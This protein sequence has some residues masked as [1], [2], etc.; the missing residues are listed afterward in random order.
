MRHC[1]TSPARQLSRLTCC[2]ITLTTA[3]VFH[4][5][6]DDDTFAPLD[7]ATSIVKVGKVAGKFKYY[8]DTTYWSYIDTT[9]PKNSVL[10]ARGCYWKHQV[11]VDDICAFPIAVGFS[12]DW[13]VT[14]PHGHAYWDACPYW[15]FES[16]PSTQDLCPNPMPGWPVR[17]PSPPMVWVGG[18]VEGFNSLKATWH[19]MKLHSPSGFNINA[20][21]A[22]V[23]GIR[24]HNTGDGIQLYHSQNFEVRNCWFSHIRDEPIENDGKR[25]GTMEDCLVDGCYVFYSATMGKTITDAPTNK[26]V[27]RNNIVSLQPMP[28]PYSKSVPDGDPNV[29]GAGKLFKINDQSPLMYLYDNVFVLQKGCRNYGDVIEVAG[30]RLK[31]SS[32]NKVI[33][34][35]DGAFEA[36]MPSGFTLVTGAKGKAMWD[37]LK[38]DWIE[39]HPKV[40]RIQGDPG[41]DATAEAT[42]PRSAGVGATSLMG[43]Q[44]EAVLLGLDGRT[45]ARIHGAAAAHRISGL[46]LP[47]GVYVVR[48]G[49]GRSVRTQKVIVGSRVSR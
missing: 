38:A 22:V 41:Y 43:E 18:V 13:R 31:E 16:D 40:A 14:P 27:I 33:W 9:Y 49:N 19:D 28:G 30:T 1:L 47:A 3:L 48:W 29:L 45:L 8:S 15:L 37:S 34:L 2:A 4:A 7:T 24:I 42:A 21:N 5:L 39:R 36:A 12:V 20:T 32:G 25:S 26:M 10:D 11:R 44:D 23:D 46:P 35:G 17:Q 6:A